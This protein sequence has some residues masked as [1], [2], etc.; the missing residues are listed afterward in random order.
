MTDD[1]QPDAPDLRRHDGPIAAAAGP[2]RPVHVPEVLHDAPGDPLDDLI[3]R[4]ENDLR[5]LRTGGYVHTSELVSDLLGALRSQCD[6][7]DQLTRE[8]IR[9]SDAAVERVTALKR[10]LAEVRAAARGVLEVMD[11]L[12]LSD[13]AWARLDEL[14]VRVPD[15][16]SGEVS[17]GSA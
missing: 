7:T 5:L 2:V 3:V 1:T 9:V 4:A 13:R 11:P 16:E 12:M 8:V 14:R 17:D 6:K 10:D 15:A